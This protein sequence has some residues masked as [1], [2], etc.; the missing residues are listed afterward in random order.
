VR[1]SLNPDIF[2]EYDIRGTVDKDLT[3]D[4]V[5]VLGAALGTYFIA[6]G[7]NRVTIGRDVRIS[8]GWIRDVLV[9]ALLGTG[10]DVVD[11]GICP[12]PLLYHASVRSDS[13]SAVVITGSHNPPEYNG[14]KL[15]LHQDPVYGSAI[16]E[17]R[18]FAFSGAFAQGIGRLAWADAEADYLQ[19]V[20]ARVDALTRSVKV[21]VDCG[22]GTAG[23]VAIPLY[24]SL[25]C[26]VIPLF[27]E[28]DGRFPG[29]HPDPTIDANLVE[30]AD[31][32]RREKADLEL[33]FD[34]DADRLGAVDGQ[35]NPIRADL[36]MIIFARAILETKPGAPVVADVKCSRRLFQDVADRGGIPIMWKTGHSLT[37]A[38]VKETGAVLGGELSGHLC[39]ADRY[40]GY[41]D[42]IYAG[43][44]LLEICSRQE[45][46]LSGLLEGIPEAF[47]TE[48]IRRECP[49]D[50]KFQAVEALK[51]RLS[52]RFTVNALDGVRLE[53]E[54]GWG[55]VRASNTQ[56]M[57]VLRFEASSPQR[58]EEIRGLVEVELR[59]SLQEIEAAGGKS[60]CTTS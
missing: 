8:S 6:S 5:A 56:P 20:K 19:D 37:R 36:L 52:Q 11:L 25:G 26:D 33:A 27:A 23:P 42:A 50:V 17:I 7:A 59:A 24:R 54:D 12:T 18:R 45:K 32:V 48:E 13:A 55:L 47:S 4:S 9:K 39:F 49:E 1:D 3:P 2:R 34:G 43:A 10:M 31:R 58:L 30:L 14:L 46:P 15:V 21:V 16:R 29:H 41:D 44:R 38:K 35:G 28:P 51:E 53:F 22:N 60:K 40:Y 57:L